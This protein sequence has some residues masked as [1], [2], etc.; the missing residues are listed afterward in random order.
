MTESALLGFLD[1]SMEIIKKNIS[2]SKLPSKR[3]TVC[4][5]HKA[6]GAVSS[7]GERT[8]VY[9]FS[10]GFWW[11]PSSLPLATISKYVKVSEWILWLPNENSISS[12]IFLHLSHGGNGPIFPWLYHRWY[13]NKTVGNSTEQLTLSADS[14][15]SKRF[16]V[17]QLL[18]LFF[19]CL[20]WN[21]KIPMSTFKASGIF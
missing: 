8:Q 1:S 18:F 13:E 12:Q 3:H 20:Q 4:V 17:P 6:S 9:A 2:P 7:Q 14:E 21:S 16:E 5:A 15:H 10:S 19:N 11:S